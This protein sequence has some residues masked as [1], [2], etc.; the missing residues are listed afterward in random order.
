MHCKGII[1]FKRGQ[2]NMQVIEECQEQGRLP[3]ALYESLSM[4]VIQITLAFAALTSS[5]VSCKDFITL[6]T[7]PL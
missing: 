7:S 6:F 5:K 3:E 4:F 2:Y 1:G